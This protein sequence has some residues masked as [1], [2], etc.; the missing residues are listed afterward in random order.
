[1]NN[2]YYGAT[3]APDPTIA[4]P[5]E[6]DLTIAPPR[7]DREEDSLYRDIERP[8]HQ[9]QLEP[10]DQVGLAGAK[11]RAADRFEWA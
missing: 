5:L 11:Q 1:M 7:R 9:D 6:R 4:P 3:I 8:S 2:K 10:T